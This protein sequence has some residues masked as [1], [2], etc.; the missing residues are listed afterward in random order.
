MFTFYSEIANAL[1]TDQDLK[2][3]NIDTST[4]TTE[5]LIERKLF[6]L[7]YAEKPTAGQY[8]YVVELNPTKVDGEYTRQYEV[9]DMFTADYTDPITEET[10]TVEDQKARYDSQLAAQA[11][12][13]T[14]ATARAYLASTDWYAIRLAETGVE[15]PE[16]I[17]EARAAARASVQ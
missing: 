14:N 16:E 17:L 12:Q 7:P 9:R 15:I 6:R 10:L 3:M 4:M 11:Q 8:E 1:L 2:I 13:Q 5:Q